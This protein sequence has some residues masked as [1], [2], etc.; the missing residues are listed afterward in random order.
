MGGEHPLFV[1]RKCCSAT[2][3]S[4]CLID[5]KIEILTLTSKRGDE[6][7]SDSFF[8]QLEAQPL[9]SFTL[10]WIKVKRFYCWTTGT[11]YSKD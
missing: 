11:I 5:H 10:D 2:G 8:N 3:L 4:P 9:L 1:V 6:S 7:E